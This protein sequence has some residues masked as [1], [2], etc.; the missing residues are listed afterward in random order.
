MWNNLIKTAWRNV[1]RN[2]S[3]AAINMASLTV[4]MAA[5]ILLFIVVSYELSFD[6]GQPNYSRITRIV[7]MH[8]SSDNTVYGSGIPYP[9]LQAVRADFPQITTAAIYGSW[10]SQV[11]V[12]EDKAGGQANRKFVENTVFFT[13]PQ[14]FELFKYTWLAGSPSVLAEPNMTVLT[15]TMAEKYFGNWQEA[16]GKMVTID[17][18]AS[19]RVAGILDDMQANT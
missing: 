2:K 15:K 1:L 18:K 11:T 5:C 9:A 3:Y 16:M 17:N 12:S 13:E 19:T 8:E 6:T 14:W 4:G 7:T 10:G